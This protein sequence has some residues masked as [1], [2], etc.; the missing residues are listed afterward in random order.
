MIWILHFSLKPPICAL[1]TA[2]AAQLACLGLPPLPDHQTSLCT[3]Y[4]SLGSIFFSKSLLHLLIAYSEK[5]IPQHE[6][7]NIHDVIG[8]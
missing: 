6:L 5:A 2:K 8:G 1:S 7:Y 4:H 3:K